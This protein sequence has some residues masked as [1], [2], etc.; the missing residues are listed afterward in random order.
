MKRAQQIPRLEEVVVQRQHSWYDR[1][2]VEDSRLVQQ[3]V[4]TVGVETFESIPPAPRTITQE[5]CDF[6]PGLCRLLFRE[7]IGNY[8]IA[9]S[10]NSLNV[11]SGLWIS[12][13]RLAV[14][15]L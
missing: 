12:R 10:E 6:I 2:L 1:E 9:V 3:R 11:C 8:D 7:A 14:Y 5:S 4:Y 15:R 13:K